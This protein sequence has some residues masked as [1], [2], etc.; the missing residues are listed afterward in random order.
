M[1]QEIEHLTEHK[2]FKGSIADL[3]G[4]SAN[5]YGM[6]CEIDC[7]KECMDCE[8]LDLSHNRLTKLLKDCLEVHGVKSVFIRS[9]IRYDLAVNS[10]KYVEQLVKHHVSGTLKIAPEH[11]SKSVLKLMNK[12]NS[13]L[14]EFVELFNKFSK[15]KN[16]SL[17]YYLMIGHPGDDMNEI[18]HLIRQVKTLQNI[19]QFQLFT[20]TPMT[21][22]TCMYWTSLDPKTLEPVVVVHD[23]NTKK[24]MK[25]AM[26]AAIKKR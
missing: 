2:E 22:S 23:Y 6:D 15:G 12:D 16:Q 3:G 1:L 24:K 19:E 17:R 25:R 9:G 26:L 18:K 11:F 21:A 10:P 13:R 4:P 14:E 20:P 5:M 7:D 8:N